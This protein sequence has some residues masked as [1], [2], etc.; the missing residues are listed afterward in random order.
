MTKFRSDDLSRGLSYDDVLLVPQRSPV[1]SRSDVSLETTFADDV[2]IEQP[3]VSAPMDTVTEVTLAKELAEN[4]G[5]GVIHRF[6]TIDEQASYV[7]DVVDDGYQVAA[8]VGVDEDYNARADSLVSAGVDALV[9]DIAHGHLEKALTAVENLSQYGVPVVA[10]NVATPEGAVDLVHAGADAVKVGIGPGAFCT[11][12]EV[13]GVGVPQ[14]TAVTECANAVPDDVAVI[15]DGGIRTSGDAAKALMAGADT[16]MMGTFFAKTREA[17]GMEVTTDGSQ[18]QARGMATS[19]ANEER[20]DKEDVDPTADEGVE[21]VVTCEGTVADRV[22]N[23]LGG[24]RSA[25]SYCGGH[26]LQE[27]RNNAEFIEIT[28][29]TERR[30]AEHYDR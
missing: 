23:F 12:R 10:G 28:S 6:L 2:T 1:D 19:A 21:G 16:V 11:T 25:V 26:T 29:A 13:T 3:L 20:T 17:A 5:I 22:D 15:A 9:F 7:A 30:N 4:G 8:A 14:L 27:A 18:N 24:I